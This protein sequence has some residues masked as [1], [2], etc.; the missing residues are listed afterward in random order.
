MN[1][2]KIDS[3]EPYF[4]IAIVLK[5]TENQYL[6]LLKYI[7]GRNGA[8]VIYQCKSLTYLRVVKDGDVKLQVLPDNAEVAA[9]L[10]G[11]AKA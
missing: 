6:R 5:G 2:K 7:H 11:E 8:S 3:S 1:K 4:Y 10:T 9:K